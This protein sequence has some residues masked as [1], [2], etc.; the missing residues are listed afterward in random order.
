MLQK[1]LDNTVFDAHKPIIKLTRNRILLTHPFFCICL[2]VGAIFNI[3]FAV[4]WYDL[5]FGWYIGFCQISPSV[6]PI[7]AF[8]MFKADALE[9][10]PSRKMTGTGN[11]QN[12]AGNAKTDKMSAEMRSVTFTN[13]QNADSRPASPTNLRNSD[14]PR[15][16]E[17]HSRPSTPQNLLLKSSDQTPERT[18]QQLEETPTRDVI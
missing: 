1:A 6:V 14:S 7:I 4:F 8:F 9:N 18:P 15:G 5:M 13:S 12:S 11:S 16:S 3:I 17:I 10:I 2:F